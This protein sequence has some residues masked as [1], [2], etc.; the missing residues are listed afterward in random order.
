MGKVDL[1]KNAC[2]VSSKT[3]EVLVDGTT[4]ITASAQG[5][6]SGEDLIRHGYAVPPSPPGE[7]LLNDAALPSACPTGRKAFGTMPLSLWLAP[8][9]GGFGEREKSLHCQTPNYPLG[10]W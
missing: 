6:K 9:W 8:P 4:S 7:G 2:V 5:A 1:M 3:D 10:E